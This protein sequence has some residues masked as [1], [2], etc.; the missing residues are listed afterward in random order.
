VTGSVTPPNVIRAALTLV[1]AAALAAACGVVNPFI[2]AAAASSGRQ[3]QMLKFAQCMRQHGID[4][5]DPANGHVSVQGSGGGSASDKASAA[6]NNPQFLA[7]QA[8]C[9]K[10]APNGGS[11]PGTAN[12]QVLDRLTQFAQ[13]MRQ[14]GVPMNDPQVNGGAI[15]VSISPAP[16]GQR[17]DQTQL[18]QAQKA[19]QK[20]QPGGGPNGGNG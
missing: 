2:P 5:S 16:G 10:Y 15:S 8:A 12:P 1:A 18:Q 20:Y 4:M 17:P 19:C 3:D 7:A 6:V 14:H 11:G 9:K 13:C